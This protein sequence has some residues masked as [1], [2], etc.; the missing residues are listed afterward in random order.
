MN[1]P[2][3]ADIVDNSRSAGE[4]PEGLV[5]PCRIEGQ[6]AEELAVLAEDADVGV[7]DEEADGGAL[8]GAPHADVVQAAEVAQ[9]DAAGLV[10]AGLSDAEVPRGGRGLGMRLE[11]GVVATSGVRPW[12]ARCGRWW[13]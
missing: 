9:R 10:Y 6:L 7:G 2:D 8:V 1:P 12:S 5:V 3:I 11:A 4:R 13:L